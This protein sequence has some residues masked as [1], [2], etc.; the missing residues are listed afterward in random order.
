MN[1]L[2][3]SLAL[4]GGYS[5]LIWQLLSILLSKFQSF[6]FNNELAQS[7]YTREKSKK[8]STYKGKSYDSTDDFADDIDQVEKVLV[9]R[10]PHKYS[11]FR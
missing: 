4:V 1:T 2:D 7:L 6:S 11:P 5:A 8:K 10:I 9:D 3:G